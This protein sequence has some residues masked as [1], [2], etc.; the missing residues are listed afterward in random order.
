MWRLRW[1]A[2]LL[3]PAMATRQLQGKQGLLPTWLGVA[4]QR[5]TVALLRVP[6]LL[7]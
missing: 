3:A 1:Q 2:S 7:G 5:A 4:L 6:A